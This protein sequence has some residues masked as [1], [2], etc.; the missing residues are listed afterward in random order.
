VFVKKQE[1]YPG[2]YVLKKNAKSRKTVHLNLSSSSPSIWKKYKKNEIVNIVE[3]R[4][5]PSTQHKIRGKIA[6]NGGW[7]TLKDIQK[8][9]EFA[10][11]VTSV[12]IKFEILL[13]FDEKE[14]KTK[15]K[16]TDSEKCIMIFKI[17]NISKRSD[18][19]EL[20]VSRYKQLYV[21]GKKHIEKS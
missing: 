8:N 18:V 5:I 7:I 17:I 15:I 9:V 2:L 3:I 20:Q 10:S 13:Q 14:L 19:F 12:T 6:N 1:L 21:C 16:R 11:L 4:Y